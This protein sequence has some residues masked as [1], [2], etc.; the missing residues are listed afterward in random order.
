MRCYLRVVS[1][2]AAAVLCLSWTGA[3]KAGTGDCAPA[4]PAFQRGVC[5][6]KNAQWQQAI[7]L[8]SPYAEAH[9]ADAA[10]W[11]W[12]A[13]AHLYQ[14]QFSP[15]L[16]S[17][18]RSIEIDNK[19]ARSYRTL[20]EIEL[21]LKDNDAAYRAWISA[22]KLDPSDAKTAYYIGRLFFEADL[23]N[24]AA[25]WFRQTLK[26]DARHF[27]AMTYLAICAERL[28]FQST[29]VELYRA[30]IRESKEQQKPFPWA[31]LNYAKYL[32]Q[33]GKDQEARV[34]L[35]EAERLCPEAHALALLGQMLA[36][37]QPE[38]AER[39][40][41]RAIALDSGI[42]EAH[43]RLAMLLRSAGR[44]DEAD[45]EFQRFQDAKSAEERSKNGIQAIRKAG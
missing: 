7:A 33:S 30:A 12:L 20:G 37:D 21:Q 41:R 13:Q 43:Y 23:L 32:R 28:E 17:I 29:A 36:A 8:L 22:N 18:L 9:Q 27:A 31:F 35:E 4:L 10:A 38:R 26:L 3:L 15:A 11:Y 16:T 45:T 5:L 34:L 14:R 24:E 42:P 19:S 44:I 1:T 2:C 39:V 25:S 6:V 40:L